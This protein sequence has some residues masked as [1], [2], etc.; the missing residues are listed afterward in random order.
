[1]IIDH[2]THHPAPSRV[3]LVALIATLLVSG[4]V[5]G[6]G[7]TPDKA[8]Y[9]TWVDEQGR[10]HSSPVPPG[11]ATPDREMSTK[12]ASARA[13]EAGG[14]PVE[15][16]ETGPGGRVIGQLAP[17]DEYTLENYPDGDELEKQGYIRPGEPLPYFTWRDAEGNIR[18]S[19]YRP[20]TRSD[21]EKGR[22]KPPLKLTV[23]SIFR[24]G[25]ATATPGTGP[26]VD[27]REGP[28]QR[29]ETG[30]EPDAYAILGI[31]RSQ[32]SFFDRWAEACCDGLSLAAAVSWQPDREFR[33]VVAADSASYPFATGQSRYQ[34]VR[35]PDAQTAGDFVVRLRS[36]ASDGVFVPSL[37]FL[38]EDLRPLRIV[39]DLVAGY[40]PE[41]WHRHGFLESL[42]PVFP[43][44][45]EH[46][47]LM[48]TRPEDAAG[49]TVIEDKRGPRVIP[50]RGFGELS[51]TS[52]TSGD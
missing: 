1:M 45:G 21:V 35:L 5:A 52:M 4:C 50:H 24:S 18:V 10:V 28:G 2:Q 33:V 8:G 27:D 12:E 3:G 43:S 23:A 44:E 15:P 30:R 26:D 38:D 11:D 25:G 7:A 47:L 36:F 32:E 40:T 13:G 14:S 46:W 20:D 39:T 6:G 51:L 29:G 17:E 34:L 31:E 48:F 16:V 9:Y 37:A 41:S 49:Q 42:V 22:V 19:Y